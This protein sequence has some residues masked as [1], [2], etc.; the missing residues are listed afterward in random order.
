MLE[1]QFFSTKCKDMNSLR[2][3]L[4]CFEKAM[5]RTMAVMN[6]LRGAFE[7]VSVAF[8]SITSMRFCHEETK[9]MMKRFTEE[10]R[11][12]KDGMYFL[13]YN[14]LVHQDVVDPVNQ[15]QTSLTAAEKQARVCR[16]ALEKYN[17]THREVEKK[18]MQYAR[19]QK[20]LEES[21]TYSKR[22]A[23]R[24]STQGTYERQKKGF[25]GYFDSL[26]EQASRVADISMRRYISLNAGYLLSVV[27]AL[28]RAAPNCEE[29]E[30]HPV[31][32][33]PRKSMKSSVVNP[34]YS[35]RTHPSQS[36]TA[37]TT[38]TAIRASLLRGSSQL[39]TSWRNYSNDP[40]A[41]NTFAKQGVYDHNVS[42]E[43]TGSERPIIFQVST[44]LLT[45]R[46]E[47][48]SCNVSSH[49]EFNAGASTRKHFDPVRMGSVEPSGRDYRSTQANNYNNT[50]RMASSF[51]GPI[52]LFNSND[53]VVGR[54][55][56]NRPTD[57]PVP[58][59]WQT[60]DVYGSSQLPNR[61]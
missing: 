7:E 34:S 11:K 54:T 15:L 52:S 47:D 57:G 29:S 1:D 46:Y 10:M 60:Q 21:K 32:E 56:R 48:A 35:A 50:Q 2:E 33:T 17:A 58:F 40:A 24:D 22:V 49:H 37:T 55:T 4:R 12:L 5:H 43:E 18:E 26:M 25:D 28:E 38:T 23:S 13:T 19:K 42:R 53:L 8:D 3:S 16:K 39:D 36:V 14:K 31:K 30:L 59:V 45:Q 27:S 6:E 61:N 20:S 9:T 41:S 51:D 44:P